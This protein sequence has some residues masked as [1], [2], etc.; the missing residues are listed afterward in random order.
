MSKTF[1]KATILSVAGG[2]SLLCAA[3]QADCTY[4][5]APSAL[6]NGSTASEGEMTAAAAAF[7]Q[8]NSDVTAYLACLQDETAAKSASAGASQAMQIKT[9]QSRKHNA[10][11]EELEANVA[12]F[13]A[14]LRAYK[15]RKA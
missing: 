11:V 7:K 15:S 3:A 5:K 4:P 10:A 13:N 6:P 12:K 14:Q 9:M 2:L 1:L 8:Y